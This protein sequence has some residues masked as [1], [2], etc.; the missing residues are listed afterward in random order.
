MEK[1]QKNYYAYLL[2]GSAFGLGLM[3]FAPGTFGTLLGLPAYC[4]CIG[5]AFES[6]MARA[7]RGIFSGLCGE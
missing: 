7:S 1:Q 4:D 3:P 6:A 5:F 2:I